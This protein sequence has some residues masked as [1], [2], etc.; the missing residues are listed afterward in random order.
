MYKYKVY[1]PVTIMAVSLFC[2]TRK[3]KKIH[4]LVVDECRCVNEFVVGIVNL[5]HILEN[6]VQMFARYLVNPLPTI[7]DDIFA[8]SR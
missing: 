7:A 6:V 4:H 3:L 2:Y 1:M 8:K 5:A